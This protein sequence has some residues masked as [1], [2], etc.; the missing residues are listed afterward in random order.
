MNLRLDHPEWLWVLVPAVLITLWGAAWFGAMTRTKRAAAVLVRLLLLVT[1]VLALAGLSVTREV[2]EMVCVLV[3]DRSGSVERHGRTADGRSVMEGVVDRIEAEARTRG[4]DDLFAAVVFDGRA[5]AVA[6][7]T[8]RVP[9]LGEATPPGAPGTDIAGAIALAS[10]MIPPS[11]TGR[12]VLISDGV[13]TAGDDRRAAAQSPYPIDVLPIEYAAGS[14]VSVEAFDAPPVA[15]E[16]ATIAARVVLSSTG[17]ARGTLRLYSEGRA[18]TSRAVQLSAGET[19]LRLEAKLPQGRVHRLLARWEPFTGEG[20]SPDAVPE[21]NSVRALT[22]TPGRGAVMLVSMRPGEPSAIADALIAE[23]WDVRRSAA[24]AIPG[25]LLA[26]QEFD[27]VVLDSIPASEVSSAAQGALAAY[28]TA[29]GGGLI[30]AGGPGSFAP[31]GWAQ[32]PLEPILPV[33]LRTPDLVV[34]PQSATILVIDN[35]GSMDRRVLGTGQSQQE[36]ANEAAVLAVR[37]L[38]PSD[39]LGVI[40]FNS[41]PSLALPL[42]PNSDPARTT[43]VLRGISA[44]G[45]T[46]LG[47]ALDLA[48]EQLARTESVK[49]KHVVV[50][51]DG[52]S[53]AKETLPDRVR[54]LVAEGVRVTTIAVG[55]GAD[56]TELA[57]LAKLGG[58]EFFHAQ[59]VAHLPRVLVRAVRIVRSPLIREEPVTVRV[60]IAGPVTAGLERAPDLGG[61]VITR[62]RPDPAAA[63]LL[64]AASGEPLLAVWPAGLGN[65]GAWTS[66]TGE[67][68]R[69]WIESGQFRT[70]WPAFARDVARPA[71]TGDVEADVEIADGSLRVVARGPGPLRATV[72]SPSG[73]AR[74]LALGQSGPGEFAGSLL[75]DEPGTHVVVIDSGEARRGTQPLVVGATLADQAEFRAR[76]SDAAAMRALAASGGGRVLSLADSRS[77]GLFDRAGVPPRSHVRSLAPE[78]LAV[79]LGLVLLDVAVRRVAWD[80]WR[81][82]TPEMGPV[83]ASGM[84]ERLRAS[85]GA[86]P[87]GDV[88]LTL[89]EQDAREL[90]A[91]ARDRRRAIRLGYSGEASQ[92]PDAEARAVGGASEEAEAPADAADAMRAAKARARR[93]AEEG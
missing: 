67:W 5:V 68:S 35:S 30:M 78:L 43:R 16:E 13:Q 92:Q 8:T 50:L 64:R 84:M 47:P 37:A 83:G 55:D 6:A 20:G 86:E 56:V 1:G 4:P 11:T 93:R 15:A 75:V 87:A 49:V 44:D 69:A 25:D 33:L 53:R 31:G 22:V 58:G 9:A 57:G 76:T 52:V 61:L 32:T 29:S 21:N 82:K 73:R 54:A 62:D 88:A 18:L 81:A 23:G 79:L 41:R 24:E 70:L 46:N 12:I 91:A 36:I 59:N 71:S 90:V 80:R 34:S 45:G 39:L 3:L 60:A 2:T 17:E 66:D 28:V 19:I 48:R 7:P 74:E 63:V 42:A 89:G 72:Y 51:T 14:D 65:V 38:D 85:L 10:R 77:W 40:T 26:L 27:L